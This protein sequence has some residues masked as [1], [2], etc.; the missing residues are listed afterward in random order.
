[1]ANIPG[2]FDASQVDPNVAPEPIPNGKYVVI[3]KESELKATS[4]GQGQLLALTLEIM[5][6]PFKG[7]K[8]YDRLNLVNKSAEAVRIARGQLSAIFRSVGVMQPRDTVELHN[9][10][11]VAVVKVGKRKDTQELKNEIKGYEKKGAASAPA[12][13]QQT[14]QPTSQAPWKR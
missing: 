5:E 10:P 6:G 8:L 9:L 14:G 13:T 12:G 11:L 2:G 3:I 7:R 1:M 4:D